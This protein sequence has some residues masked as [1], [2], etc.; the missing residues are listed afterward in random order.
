MN[1]KRKCTG[2]KVR[3]SQDLE[4]WRKAPVGYFHNND[5]QIDYARKTVKAK[6]KSHNFNLKRDFLNNDRSHQVKRT[7]T[8]FNKYIRER[9]ALKPCITC[10]N[11][12]TYIQYHAGHY[13][14][15]GARPEHRFNPVNCHKQC[16]R[17]NNWLSGN[18]ANYRIALIERYGLTAVENLEADHKPKKYGVEALKVIQKWNQRKLKRLQK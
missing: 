5:C 14:S 15:V 11:S 2:C 1:S 16:A 4:T 10:G 12:K 17:C 6:K 3:F 18:V 13:L 8:I 7:Q 9:D